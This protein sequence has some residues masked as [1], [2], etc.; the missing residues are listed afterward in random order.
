MV[1]G[2][3]PFVRLGRCV[4]VPV[5]YLLSHWELMALWV[6]DPPARLRMGKIGGLRNQKAETE[7]R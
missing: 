7:Q 6:K 3:L 1:A 4:V 5:L 2:S